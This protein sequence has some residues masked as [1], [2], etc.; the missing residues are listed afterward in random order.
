MWLG[1]RADLMDA[2]HTS[3]FWMKFVYTLA[4]AG[5][6]FWA[7]LRL[8][9]PGAPA[10]TAMRS[11]LLPVAGMIGLGLLQIALSHGVTAPMFYGVPTPSARSGFS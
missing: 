1:P 6:A 11:I 9:H 5:L 3:P 8:A 2:M 4:F 10:R 7:A